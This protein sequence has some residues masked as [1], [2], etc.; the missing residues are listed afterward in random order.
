MTLN[1][2]PYFEPHAHTEWQSAR[3]TVIH[4]WATWNAM[5]RPFA[6]RL[7]K[8]SHIYCNDF[9]MLTCEFDPEE[10]WELLR[11][12]RVRGVPSLALFRYGDH[13]QTVTGLGK[14]DYLPDTF[15]KWLR[16]T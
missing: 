7:H 4:F 1:W 12:A 14:H 2:G 16:T 9:K 8:V 11:R 3:R 5:D 10:N 15:A 13:L 6:E